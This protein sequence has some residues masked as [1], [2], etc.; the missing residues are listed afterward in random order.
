MVNG[1][2]TE[3]F[4]F[5]SCGTSRLNTK[6][7]RNTE[8]HNGDPV[9]RAERLY[10]KVVDFCSSAR[11]R[12]WGFVSTALVVTICLASCK[13]S[14]SVIGSSPSPITS[15]GSVLEGSVVGTY[16]PHVVEDPKI[17]KQKAEKLKVD[18]DTLQK[19]IDDMKKI[20][21]VLELYAD[22]T[23]YWGDPDRNSLSQQGTWSLTEGQIQLVPT[24]V[25]DG[26]NEVVG[27]LD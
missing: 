8:S 24:R 11:F 12:Q 10:I 3:I 26:P 16:H 9:L 23:F 2:S 14:S 7:L 5:Q 21:I 18:V 19:N 4:E 20:Q 22:H 13:H 6:D 1:E 27:K 25:N 15:R 17:L